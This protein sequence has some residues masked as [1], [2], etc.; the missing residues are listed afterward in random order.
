M[1]VERK[2]CVHT[3]MKIKEKEIDEQGFGDGDERGNMGT[4][5][6]VMSVRQP[7]L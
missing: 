2:H 4:Y 6:G 7:E 5:T 1:L 3:V